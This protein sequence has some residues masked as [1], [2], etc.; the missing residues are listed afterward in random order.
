MAWVVWPVGLAVLAAT[1]FAA[2]LLP[3]RRRRALAAR[4]AW[5]AARAAIAAAATSRD[6]VP[7]DVPEADDALHQAELLVAGGGGEQ[8][9]QAA[10]EHARR[11]DR[12]WRRVAGG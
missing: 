12:L 8:A 9:A 4:T 10:A 1:G 7:H 5:S 2:A 6:A 11:A 3:R